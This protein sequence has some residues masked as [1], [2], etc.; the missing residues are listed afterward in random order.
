MSDDVLYELFRQ[1]D[2]RQQQSDIDHYNPVVMLREVIETIR[3]TEDPDGDADD[4][5]MLD[6]AL[7]IL[8][9]VAPKLSQ[10]VI[11]E[12]IEGLFD[13]YL[14]DDDEDEEYYESNVEF[15]DEDMEELVE[16]FDL[17]DEKVNAVQKKRL[18]YLKK[19]RRSQLGKRGNSV[20]FKRTHHFDSKSKRFVKRKKAITVSAMRKKARIF[21]KTMRKGSSKAKAKRMKKRL[22]HV[23]NP[24]GK[25]KTIK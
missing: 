15:S 20:A 2:F 24:Y 19:K 18:R 14:D 17:L 25:I 5:G 1:G 12:I 3:Y 23:K 6:P 16:S 8:Y 22:S 13:Y 10:D 11:E 9:E 4:F 21:K 7:E